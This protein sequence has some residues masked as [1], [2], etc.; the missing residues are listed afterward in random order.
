MGAFS[1]QSSKNLN[2]GEG[3]IVLTN[4]D[5]LAEAARSLADCGH[6][7]S[8]P[9]Y[10][11]YSVA[12]NHR[13]TE[14]QGALLL[15][16][17][18]I[19]R[20]AGKQ[21]PRERRLPDRTAREYRRYPS[22]VQTREGRPPRAASLPVQIQRRSLPGHPEISVSSR[23]CARKVFPP[24]PVTPFPCTSSRSSGSGTTAFTKVM[25]CRPS[26]SAG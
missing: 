7:P 18:G 26:N 21:A 17:D 23:P 24:V 10:N 14:M 11:H 20:G 4:D 6:V 12:G 15:V 2:A 25:R 8:E 3:G 19:S 1:F 16:P 22:G 9:R 5:G 13:M